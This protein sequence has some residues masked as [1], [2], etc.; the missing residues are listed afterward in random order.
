METVKIMGREVI[1]T[2]PEGAEAK[3]PLAGLLDRLAPKRMD[4]GDLI[5]PDGVKSV[6][7]RPP[8]VILV[9]QTSPQPVGVKWIAADSAADF[10]PGTSY[11]LVRIGVPYVIVLAVFTSEGNGDLVLTDRNECFFRAAP[12]RSLDDVLLYPGLLNCSK[13][14]SQDGNPLSWICTQHLDRAALAAT[15]APARRIRTSLH[16]LLHCLWETG[17]N[18]SSE[19][20]EGTS[21]Y[22]VSRG[23]DERIATVE[24]WQRA[25]DENELVG[26]DIP[27]LPTHLTLRQVADRIF[28]NQKAPRRRLET[29]GDVARLVFNQKREGS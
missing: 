22:E 10:G 9:H 25:T 7:S 5:L 14:A 13:F 20:H 19:R 11:R 24:N 21:W 8:S 4:T 12:L 16:A 23:V 27:W 1:A 2:T 28:D 29:S 3:A 17:F 6:L 18:R 15:G 26:L